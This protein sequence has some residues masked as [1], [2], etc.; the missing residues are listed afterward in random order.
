MCDARILLD[1]RFSTKNYEIISEN[2]ADFQSYFEYENYYKL[3]VARQ[4]SDVIIDL[5]TCLPVTNAELETFKVEQLRSYR[6]EALS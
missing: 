4:T 5:L 2:W 1:K 3:S 6:F